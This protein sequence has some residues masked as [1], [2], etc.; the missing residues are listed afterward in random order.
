MERQLPADEWDDNRCHPSRS[1]SAG[2]ASTLPVD[3]VI[4]MG[5]GDLSYHNHGHY[6]MQF[7]RRFARYVPVLYVNSI[8]VR[9]PSVGEG[10]MFWTRVSRK[11]RSIAKGV[12]RVGDHL[13]AFSPLAIPGT[14]GVRLSRHA[15]ALQVRRAAGSIGIR[16]PVF[17]VTCPPGANTVPY[18]KKVALIYQRTDRW[19]CF[20]GADPAAI[21][22]Y[23]MQLKR[24][25][26]LTLFAAEN[27]YAQENAYCRQPLLVDHG[28][29]YELFAAGSAALEVPVDIS[30]IPRPRVGF[31]GGVDGH[32]FDL[33]L[34]RFIAGHLTQMSFV[35]VGA[36]SLEDP[37][38]DRPNVFTLGQRPYAAVPRYM[39]SCDVLIMPWRRNEWIENCNPVKLKEYL[40]TGRP[41]VTTPFPELKN[42]AGLVRVAECAAQFAKE[43]LAALADPGDATMRQARVRNDTWETR[44]ATVLDAL[45]ESGVRLPDHAYL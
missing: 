22:A 20:P 6:D 14:M 8:G 19:E 41:V 32:T 36:R 40:A 29:D 27:L 45:G 31:V 34:F 35:V 43:I 15:L 30:P 1:R 11:A 24:S 9:V 12:W 33:D 3:G 44:F 21:R 17:W 5:G 42:Y 7:M 16:R 38:F 23:D 25:A 37:V 2:S 4:C 13:Y 26:D 39:A 28:V 10:K 18:I